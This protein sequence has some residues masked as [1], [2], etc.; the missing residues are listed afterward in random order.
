MSDKNPTIEE[1]SAAYLKI[2]GEPCSPEDAAA[3]SHDFARYRSWADNSEVLQSAL[4][5]S[6]VNIVDPKTISEFILE[7]KEASEHHRFTSDWREQLS[8]MSPRD[9]WLSE[10]GFD[11]PFGRWVQDFLE[12]TQEGAAIYNRVVGL[13]AYDQ[14]DLRAILEAIVDHSKKVPP[15][16]EAKPPVEI[17]DFLASDEVGKLIG[18]FCGICL[19]GARAT[20]TIHICVAS[21][22]A[23]KNILADF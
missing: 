13:S 12:E 3:I 19:D 2:Y 6:I 20:R 8:K 10:E 18:W 23:K 9:R 14:K 11:N 16:D 15:P 21:F 17:D 4:K 5:T 7:R 1:T 22:F